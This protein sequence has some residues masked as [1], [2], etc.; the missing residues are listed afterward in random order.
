MGKYFKK[1]VGEKCFLSPVNPDDFEKYTEW[2]NDP[3]ISENM[4]VEDN[5]ISLLKEKDILEKMA[6]GNDVF[7]AI[8]DLE[9]EE[10]IGNCGLHDINRINQS[11]VLGIFIG[12]REYLSKGYGTQAIKLLLNYG[13]N[14]LN[15]NNI[16]LEV[17]EYNKR[18]IRSYQ[19]AGFKEI[20]RRRQA[21]FFKN[22]RYDII[23]MDILREEF[24]EIK[25]GKGAIG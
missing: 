6:K 15:L 4:M 20:G 8:V 24:L 17:F 14:V 10:L 3:E 16:M 1:V 7:F 21:K 5:I 23:F 9:T 18:A 13:F 11:A 19:K 22:N 25:D 12:N 2:L